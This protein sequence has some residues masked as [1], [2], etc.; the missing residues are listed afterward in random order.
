[1][2]PLII[3]T[4]AWLSLALGGYSSVQAQTKAPAPTKAPA[5][6]PAPSGSGA[7]PAPV[8]RYQAGKLSTDPAQYI[9]DV[10]GMMASTNNAAARAVGV[11]LKELWGTNRLTAS[12]QA[13][14]VALSQ[15]MLAKK[16]RPRPHFEAFFKALVGGTSTAKLT[17]QQMDQYLDVLGQT[18]EKEA[19]QETEK[20]IFST[21]RFLNG[22][23]L[24][25]S[26][27]NRLRAMGGTVSFAYSPVVAPA[28]NLEFGTPA[29]A[30]KEEP[31]PVAKPEAKKPVAAKVPAKAKPAPKKKSS[32]GWDT[33]DLWSSPSGGGWGDTDDGWGAPVKKKAPAKKPAA[34]GAPVAAKAA[35][36]AKEAAP[37]AQASDF[38]APTASFTPSATY[39][40]YSAP[41][42]RGAVIV[43]KDADLFM[44][45]AG[46]SVV[47]KKV[48]GMAVPNSDRFLASGAQLGW[49]IT[50]N[51]VT[52]DIGGFDFDMAKPEF[53]AQ[54]VMLTYPAV[55]EGSVKGALSYKSTRR[56][57]G[58]ADT[59]YPRF[60]SLTNDARIKNLGENIQYRGGLS[61]AG[62]A[63][64]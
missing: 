35:A 19:P 45:T 13:R 21:S 56:K 24:H 50:N 53:T 27:Y 28:S 42:A 41:P 37:V 52:A 47:L 12:Q 55:L 20:F 14:V 43:L 48:S 10:Q 1:M 2:K 22:G 46:D 61:M 23:Y 9:T 49:S 51:P 64:S 33:A 16:F 57:P 44:A 59:G 36:P 5:K 29:P 17:D 30:P 40:E 38:E 39:D 58:A 3:L 54:P 11:S 34:K 32:S 62:R 15:T 60:I 6:T 4:T 63:D 25:R 18:L 31:Q 8:P 7:A 26:G